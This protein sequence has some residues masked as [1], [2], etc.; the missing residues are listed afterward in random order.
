MA[1]NFP[2]TPVHSLSEA[3]NAAPLD[4]VPVEHPSQPRHLIF[5]LALAGL[6]LLPLAYAALLL[7]LLW[8]Q[9]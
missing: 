8:S 7:A 6:G 1:D 3:L 5:W 2:R 9:S 4:R